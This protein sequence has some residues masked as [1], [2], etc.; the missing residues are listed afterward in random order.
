MKRDQTVTNEFK[1]YTQNK[2][3]LLDI[4]IFNKICLI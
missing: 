3:L 2:Y 4:M 1:K